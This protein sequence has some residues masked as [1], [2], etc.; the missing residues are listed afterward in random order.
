MKEQWILQHLILLD[1]KDCC[2]NSTQLEK[3]MS[4][5]CLNFYKE[6]PLAANRPSRSKQSTSDRVICF[7]VQS[8]NEKR[9]ILPVVFRDDSVHIQ[10]RGNPQ[11]SE[12]Q[13]LTRQ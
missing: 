12:L 2:G 7:I 9:R 4:L 13:S 1:W 8:T 5:I 10:T 11:A 3:Q 6:K